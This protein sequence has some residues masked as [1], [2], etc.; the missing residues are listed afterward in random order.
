[1]IL[2]KQL[3]LI[4]KWSGKNTKLK[5]VSDNQE[6]SNIN[7]RQTSERAFCCRALPILYGASS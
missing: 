3:S 1:M 5:I 7:M 4:I 2:E 6:A